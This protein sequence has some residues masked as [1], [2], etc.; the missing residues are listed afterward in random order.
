MAQG[1]HA[2]AIASRPPQWSLLPRLRV[3]SGALEEDGVAL[4]ATAAEGCGAEAAAAALQLVED[5]ERDA[6]A[7]H[8]DRVAEG[9]GAAVDVGDLVGDAEL[10]HRCEADGGEGLV[11]LE[12]RHVADRLA[13]PVERPEDR[14]RGLV[15]QRR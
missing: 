4:A 10:G 15:E 5:R 2:V 14:P 1:P 13:G 12:E 8:A 3:G 6:G 9:D 7:R 11:E